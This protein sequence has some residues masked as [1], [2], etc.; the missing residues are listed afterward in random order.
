M[1]CR[2]RKSPYPLTPFVRG[3]IRSC[4][5]NRRILN[6]A[7]RQC[8]LEFLN[9]LIRDRGATKIKVFQACASTQ[10]SETD[11]RDRRELKGKPFKICASAQLSETCIRYRRLREAKV[12]EVRQSAQ[13]SQT[14]T[15]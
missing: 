2:A 4:P 10:S 6:I 7:F 11:I 15:R 9:P 13:M 1:L 8:D 14:G 12:I 5:R 3:R